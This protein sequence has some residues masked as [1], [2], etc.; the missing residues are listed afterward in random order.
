VYGVALILVMMF[1][2]DG[3]A[4]GLV[5]LARRIVPR[6]APP[7]AAEPSPIA[8]SAPLGAIGGG[9]RDPKP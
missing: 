4:G 6:H 2:P 5:G 7:P 1:V 9:I 8:T 3:I